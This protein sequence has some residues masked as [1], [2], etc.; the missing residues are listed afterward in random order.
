M[1]IDDVKRIHMIGVGGIGMSA[2]ARLLLY[3][4]KIVSGS[5]R[6]PSAITD[7]LQREGVRFAATQTRDN[8]DDDIE[9][10]IYTEALPTGHEELFAAKQKGIPTMNYFEALGMVVNPYYLIAVAGSHGKTTTTAML[11]DILE[12]AKYDPT[13]IVGS[14][15]SKTHSNFRGGKSKYC[16]VEACEY[17]R[18][19]LYLKPEVLVIT[20]IEAE[21]LDYYRD[22]EDIISAFNTLARNVPEGGFI[23][24]N[25]K[26]P[27]VKRALEGVVA[28]VVDYT[29]FIDVLAPLS[30]PGMHN[31][32]NAAAATAAAKSIGI[33]RMKARD[34]L[35]TFKGTWRRFEYKGVMDN[36][37]IVYDDYGHHPTEIVATIQGARELYPKRRILLV[38]QPHT[39]SRTHALFEDFVTAFAKADRSLILPIYA[40]RE[41]NASGVSSEQLAGKAP[42]SR[43]MRS[44]EEAFEYIVKETGEEDVVL[45]MGAGDIYQLSEALV[46]TA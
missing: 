37:A 32:L 28:T 31:R 1:K 25:I 35:A 10:V 45:V 27:A 40:A 19:F 21:H 33:D 34:S 5:D 16:V 6:A 11:I 46:P 15:R 18:D 24:A 2:L 23:V 38:F 29:Q 30:Q 22:L 13:A 17:K 42:Y 36:G 26:D 3:E 8:I 14:L 7:A 9:L 4:K 12:D 41:E 43:A 20:N 44:F 39:Y